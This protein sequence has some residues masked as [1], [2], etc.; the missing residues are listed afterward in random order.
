MAVNESRS[1][2]V[3]LKEGLTDGIVIKRTPDRGGAPEV[4]DAQYWNNEQ[5]GN[6]DGDGYVPEVSSRVYNLNGV[7]RSGQ[8]AY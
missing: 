6:Y 1:L 8:R 2:N 3:D 7:K 4:P 5:H